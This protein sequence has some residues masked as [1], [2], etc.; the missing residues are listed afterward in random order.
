[1]PIHQNPSSRRGRWRLRALAVALTLTSSSAAFAQV[2]PSDADRAAARQLG[3]QGVEAFQA[4]DYATAEDKLH[5]AFEVV[6][7]PTLGLWLARTLTKNQRW[8]EA[9]EVYRE[10]LRLE[11]TEGKVEAQREA[12]RTAQGELEELEGKIPSVVVGVE[13]AAANEVEVEIDGVRVPPAFLGEARPANPGQHRVVGKFREQVLERTVE[14]A[15]GEQHDVKLVFE[16]APDEP[17]PPG[18]DVAP[19]ADAEPT[20]SADVQRWAGWGALGVGA[21][22]LVVGSVTG[23]LVLRKKGELERSEHCQGTTCEKAAHGEVDSY[24]R[25]RTISGVGFI[26]G[27]IAA[28]AGATLL[29]TSSTVGDEGETVGAY[30]G[31]GHAGLRGSF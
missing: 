13:G 24:N 3:Y 25:L 10:V 26:V 2:A 14:L 4:Q 1:M 9:A 20:V 6:K 8:V 17:A 30:V 19:P 28:A 7:V 27:G 22:G 15:P 16:P 21:A 12:Q 5:R 23:I 18:N 31:L 29:L 11:P